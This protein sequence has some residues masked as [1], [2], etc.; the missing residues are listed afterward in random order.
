MSTAMPKM[1][2]TSTDDNKANGLDMDG[3]L[4]S[5]I[6]NNLIY[7]NGRH[8]I[9]AFRIDAA[10]GPRA[11]KIINNTCVVPAGYGWGIKL[12]EDLGGH[13]I[14][15]NILAISSGGQGSI[16]VEN[17]TL[18]SNANIVDGR[19][20][21]GG[22]VTGLDAWHKL[23]RGLRS[24][25]ASSAKLFSSP[26]TGDYTLSPQSIAVDAGIDTLGTGK[27]PSHDILLTSR[28]QGKGIDIGAIEYLVPPVQ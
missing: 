9:R 12:T 24:R 27:A 2:S 20:S 6:T 4:H 26:A 1:V 7:N 25:V 13:S 28:P 23:G 16:F 10:Q 5:E 17:K 21:R 3:V 22:A 19:F 14:F 15:N 11:L 18:F 8:A